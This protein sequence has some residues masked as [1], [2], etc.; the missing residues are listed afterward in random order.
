MQRHRVL[1]INTTHGRGFG[2][3]VLLCHLLANWRSD[4]IDLALL[5]PPGTAAGDIA[6]DRGMDT[7][8]LATTRDSILENIPALCRISRSLPSIDLIHAW[9]ARGFELAVL[10]GWWKAVPAC[11]TQHDHPQA[12]FHGIPRRR[13]IR[14]ASSRFARLI[15]VSEAVERVCHELQPAVV[16][17]VIRNGV[18]DLSVSPAGRKRH[19]RVSI[20]FLGMYAGWKGFHI[21][22]QWVK[23]TVE[24]PVE[25]RLYGNVASALQAEAEALALEYPDRVRIEWHQPTQAIFS[26]ID[27]LAQCSTQFEPFGLIIIEAMRS[28]IPYVASSLGGPSEI[29]PDGLAGLLY[30][31]PGEG[32]QKLRCLVS[33][34]LLRERLGRAGRKKYEECYTAARMVGQYSGVWEET[35]RSGPR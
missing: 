19:D 12:A 17:T 9:H 11:G 2:A 13:L 31:T 26:T 5:T 7:F 32:L 16:A 10:L 4:R 6:R 28:G 33:D 15:C 27:I 8:D 30:Q 1:I 35:I 24:L 29:A 14:W 25:W 23:A 20:G 21:I 34:A 22:S 3:E 18:P